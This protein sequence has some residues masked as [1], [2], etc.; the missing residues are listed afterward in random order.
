ML[1]GRQPRPRARRGMDR[2]APADRAGR[3]SSASSTAS[4]P[5][6]RRA[7]RARSPSAPRPAPPRRSPTRAYGC[8][9]TSTRCTATGSDV[10]TTVPTFE[11]LAAGA[12]A[13]WIVTL[14]PDGATPDD[15]EAILS[16]LY[17]WMHAL[18][19]RSE[20]AVL[21]AGRGASARAWVALAGGRAHAPGPR[22]LALGAGY[23]AR[24]RAPSTRSASA[25]SSATSRAPR[26]AAAACT[27]CARCCAAWRSARRTSSGAT[28]TAPARGR[29]TTR[30]E[31]VTPAGTRHPQRGLL[32]LP[33]PL[34]RPAPRCVALLAGH[35]R[36]GRG[37]RAAAP[38][39]P[40]GG[41]GPR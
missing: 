25:R 28:R 36:P 19:Q 27:G 14:P 41:A 26:C 35:G 16:P 21:S 38:H 37:R 32:G 22:A 20:H 2:R 30:S 31:W 13:R 10:H 15:Y 7:G 24:D 17:A 33:A 5:Q 40:A 1:L 9:R 11:R 3:A 8:A 39:P 29:A 12:M 6:G 4:P 18:T 23:G 34:P